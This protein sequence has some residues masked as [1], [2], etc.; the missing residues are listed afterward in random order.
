MLW[1]EGGGR[2]GGEHSVTWIRPAISSSYIT[3]NKEDPR[4]VKERSSFYFPFLKEHYTVIRI[5]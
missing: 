5:V 4:G 1:W 2:G 3:I